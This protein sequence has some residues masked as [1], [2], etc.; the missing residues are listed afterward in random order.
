MVTKDGKPT[1]RVEPFAV[2][3]E[4][5]RLVVYAEIK[6]ECGERILPLH[7]QS[8]NNNDPSENRGPDERRGERLADNRHEKILLLL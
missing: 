4:P 7:N 5:E 2:S 3:E 1:D 8:A 6:V